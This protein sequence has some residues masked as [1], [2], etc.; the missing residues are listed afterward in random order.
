M[1][2]SDN[3]TTRDNNF[4]LLRFCAASMVLFYHSFALLKLESPGGGTLVALAVD[5]FIIISGFL[6]TKSWI[7]NPRLLTFFRKRF[8]RIVP[9]LVCSIVFGVFVIGPLVTYVS[10]HK[11]VTDPLT[12]NY[13]KNVFLYPIHYELPGVFENNPYP[14]AVNGSLWTLPI[15]VFLYGTVMV[16][17]LFGVFKRRY[18]VALFVFLLLLLDVYFRSTLEYRNTYV[19][20]MNA[21]RLLK[22]SILFFVGSLGYLY[23]EKIVFNR[24]F[25]LLLLVLFLISFRVSYGSIVYFFTLPYLVLYVA[26]AHIPLV[27]GF[28]NWSDVSY[29]TYVYAFP[30][31]QTLIYFFN[32]EINV[33]ALLLLS[34]TTTL[35]IAYA[36]WNGVEKRCLQLKVRLSLHTT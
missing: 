33:A 3:V 12:I 34:Y 24:T 11:Y 6:V 26:Y 16:L 18:V 9:A 19:L 7:D 15:E 36:S 8:L 5:I 30:V 29:G 23:N 2:L 22:L 27:K 17:G 14:F 25:V 10:M 21:S 4:T 1:T 31:Q 32:N 13:L 35:I 20:T 28:Q